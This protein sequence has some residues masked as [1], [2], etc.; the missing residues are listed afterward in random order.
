M[1]PEQ[2]VWVRE[3]VWPPS[4]LRH[5]NEIPGTFLDC[6]CQRPPSIPCQSGNHRA[7]LHDGHPIRETVVQTST[8]RAAIFRE[9]YEHRAPAGRNGRRDVYGTNNLAWVWLAGAPCR[10]ICA[11]F[12]HQP[13]AVIP[14]NVAA[15]VQLDLFAGVA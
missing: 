7:C 12:C 2:A 10:E 6:A 3:N 1:N 14:V 11:C 4:W 13:G 9:P 5:Y 8:R 15:S